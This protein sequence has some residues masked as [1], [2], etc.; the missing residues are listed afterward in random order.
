MDKSSYKFKSLESK[1]DNFTAPAFEITVG[2]LTFDTQIIPVSDLLVDI[3]SGTG[4]GGCSFTIISL[5]DYKNSEFTENILKKV[6]V[7]AD[8]TIKGGY[9][10]K[11]EIFF[12][13]VDDFSVAFEA[14]DSPKIIVNGIDA[15]G[16]LMNAKS[17][18]YMG[19]KKS[20]EI[21]KTL[22]N[23]CVSEG[24][25]KEV[26][27]GTVPPFNAQIIQEGMN[28]YDFLCF[29]AEMSGVSFFVVNGE[30]VFDDVIKN[31]GSMIDLTLGIGLNSFSKNLTL[32]K[33]VGKVIVYGI[34]PVTKKE[35]QGEST[36]SG[37][38]FACDIASGFGSVTEKINSMFVAT[39]DECK[40]LAQAKFN[41]HSGSFLTGK[42]TCV[43]LPELIP[44]RYVTLA[45][46]DDS[47]NGKYYVSKVQ[48]EFGSESGY[49][50]HFE[51]KGATS[52]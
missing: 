37:S 43:G 10:K 7:G 28:N 23:D 27:V 11:E 36:K 29:I 13:F 21:V 49:Y 51:V 6:K 8:I 2:G 46:L 1:Y 32:R 5:Y 50:T 12:G 42:G 26:T 15:K 14:D 47:C 40:K 30:I 35:I 34:D 20:D 22:L 41:A 18:K 16:F 9:I 33:Q 45:G 24:Y 44:G 4:A 48:H 3:D 31:T 38:K 17:E 39:P 52:E 19:E 25:A